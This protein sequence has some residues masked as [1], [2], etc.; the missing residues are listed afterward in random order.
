MKLTII[1]MIAFLMQASASGFAQRVTIVDNNISLKRAFVAIRKQTGYIVLS[2]SKLL[3]NLLPVKLNLKNVPLATALTTMLDQQNLEFSFN[4]KYIIITEKKEVAAFSN[5][6]APIFLQTLSGLITDSL[7]NPLPG[8]TVTLRPGKLTVATDQQGRF[9]FKDVAP[10]RY[11][12]SISS[13]G[14]FPIESK[15]DLTEKSSLA[16]MLIVLKQAVAILEEVTINTG[17]QRIKPEQS[18]GA[19]STISTKDYESRISTDFLSGLTNKL[20]G[21]LINS[22]IKFE[23]NSLFQVRGISTIGGNKSPLIVIDGYPTELTLDMIDPNEIKSVTV[24]KDAAS[25]TIYGVR[26]SNGVIVI[27]LKQAAQG[28]P[29]VTFRS[30][31]GF[32]PKEDYTRYRWDEDGTNIIIAKDNFVNTSTA[33][34]PRLG[35]LAQGFQYNLS[36]NTLIRIRQLANIITLDQAT[37]QYAELASYNNSEDYGKLFL[38]TAKT[39]TD[40]LSVSGG[41][42]NVLYYFTANH[43]NS[44][45]QQRNTGNRRVLL[46]GRS[47]INFSKKL[48]MELTTDFLQSNTK[49]TSIPDINS[50]YPYERFQ[51]A[52]GNPLP[53]FSGSRINPYYNKTLMDLGLQDNLYY[54][55]VDMN[56]IDNGVKTTSNRIKANFTYAIADHLRLRIGGVYENAQANT[57]NIA[58][59]QSSVVHQIVNFYTVPTATAGTLAYNVPP[60][61]YLQQQ[62]GQTTSFTGRAQLDYNKILGKNHSIN[63]IIGTEVRDV[64]DQSHRA[65]YFGYSDQSLLQSPV[66]NTLLKSTYVSNYLTSNSALDYN[67]LFRKTYQEDRYLSAY[68]NVV[69]TYLRKYTLSGS[70]RIDQSNLFG[71]DPKYK[72]KP[73]WSV[74]TA[75]NIDREAFMD[76][77]PWATSVKL[78]AA[79]GFNANVAKNTLPEVIASSSLNTLYPV[80]SAPVTSLSI[81][82]YAN[83]GLRWEQTENTTLGL[84]YTIF[85]TISG[86]LDYYNK[87]STDLL[88][89]TQIDATYGG[90]SALVN[91]ASV[92]NEG[93]EVGLQAGWFRRKNLDWNTGLS[94][95]RNTS[96]VLDVYNSSLTS[97]SLSSSY[98]TGTN[99]NYFK[100]FPV[101]SMFEY[102]YA[103]LNSAGQPLIYK[104]DGSTHVLQ[105]PDGRRDDVY[106][107]G[108]T[109]PSISI[110]LSNRIDIGRFYFYCMINYYGSFNVKAPMPTP[111][112]LRPI[113]GAGNYWKKAGD[114]NTPNVLPGL[115]WIS[116]V[117]S[118]L[119]NAF[120]TYIVR[121]DY[122]SIADVTASYNF[123]GSG[124]F[125]RAGLKQ[126][127]VKVQGSNLYT[128]AWNKFNYSVATGNYAKPYVTPTYT[129]ALFTNF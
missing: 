115:S 81:S 36:P 98:V 55:L 34:G 31:F 38:Q 18:T 70:I 110:G 72:Y 28:K 14:Y 57:N 16:P 7:S 62:T 63:G 104:A 125:K 64:I 42:Q 129:V 17:Y 85:N 44:N 128:F 47:T 127:E 91:Q 65:A 19:V 82:S 23:G 49:S 118:P 51:D 59:P 8:V 45:P 22:D 20:P 37:Q 9:S 6:I 111:Y 94:F 5:S 67:T 120:D 106:Y 21:L 74:G 25:S 77:L 83:S 52:N 30:T 60:G 105:T 99:T 53:V 12:L 58:S 121:G 50:I 117:N 109:I 41:N 87:K 86:N 116:P 15:V 79:Y 32:T 102:R 69:Y 73:L 103:G 124:F 27:E 96:K 43:T 114:E 112:S 68:S 71:T 24:L 4:S 126:F 122:F 90:T 11:I 54:P 46:S 88:A 48:S 75:W 26:A 29:Q 100:G 78:R 10:G 61:S 66:D 108:S 107:A 95:S 2:K 3:D 92:R 89:T 93:F 56:E 80:G 40:N 101:G 97:A 13:L 1:L 76:H 123:A 84:D 33:I 113:D 119:V 39:Q 35:T